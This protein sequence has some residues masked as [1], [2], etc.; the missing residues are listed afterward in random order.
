MASQ[1]FRSTEQAAESNDDL[2][3]VGP[4]SRGKAS[5][6]DLPEQSSLSKTVGLRKVG[7]A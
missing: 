3:F 7:R 6:S 4:A 2:G 5:Q 1:L